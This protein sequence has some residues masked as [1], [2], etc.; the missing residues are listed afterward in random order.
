MVF[1]LDISS[2][3]SGILNVDISGN[4][5]ECERSNGVRVSAEDVRGYGRLLWKDQVWLI[6]HFPMRQC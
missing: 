2:R 6:D 1:V 3:G 4:E 5:T